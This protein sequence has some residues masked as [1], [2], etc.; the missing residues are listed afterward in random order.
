M[1]ILSLLND[2]ILTIE[3]GHDPSFKKVQQIKIDDY[4]VNV[5]LTNGGA[6]TDFGIVI[7]QEKEIILGLL[8]VKNIYTKYHQKNIAVKKVGEDLLEIDNQLIK[9]NRY[10]YF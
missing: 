6:T 5:Y 4:I 8:L 7:R 2:M 1:F 3:E 10:V 9:L